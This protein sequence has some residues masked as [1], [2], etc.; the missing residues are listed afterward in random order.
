M[1][2]LRR[3]DSIAYLNRQLL[4]TWKWSLYGTFL[5]EGMPD[6]NVLH[7]Y[8]V[9]KASRGMLKPHLVELLVACRFTP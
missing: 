4:A 3:I 1:R 9:T 5:L 7:P 6:M 8:K 2:P